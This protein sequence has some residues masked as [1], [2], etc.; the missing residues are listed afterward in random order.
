M[1]TIV[2]QSAENYLKDNYTNGLSIGI[3]Y[4]GT[5]HSYNFAKSE[6][7]SEKSY[8][9]IGSVAKTFVGSVL[10]QATIDKKM[11]LHDDI[12][13]YLKGNYPNLQYQN[14]P[15]TVLHLANHTSALPKVFRQ[16]PPKILDSLRNLGLKDQVGFYA[17]Y[18]KDSLLSD[19]H[20]VKLDTI[21][22]TKFSY[23]STAMTLLIAVL[24]NVYNNSYENI[25]TNYLRTHLEITNTKPFLRESEMHLS[26]QGYN[27]KGIP[28]QFVN[29]RGYYFGPTM[30]S[31]IEDM[32]R[33]I[34][35]NLDPRQKALQ[36]THQLTFG[37]KSGFGVGL[38]WMLNTDNGKRYIYHDGNTKIGFNTLCT[39]YP[40]DKLG[41]I[42]I[43][44]DT[45]DHKRVEEI[46]NSIK[47]LILQ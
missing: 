13:K 32:L 2:N 1:D 6:L 31:T 3:Y 22:G 29:L 15:I 17:L 45:V 47:Q 39:L 34:A 12:R 40:D 23:N 37:S 30:N 26:V 27:N 42:I 43:A 16:F 21:P 19:L 33:Y 14:K 44:N 20:K 46:E 24:E 9:N 8:Y 36:M 10:A 38:G 4:K 28:Q 25:V 7:A 11:S 18:T 5:S 35:A 41:I